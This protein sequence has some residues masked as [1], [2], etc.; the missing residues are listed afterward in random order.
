MWQKL[1]CKVP[2]NWQ[3]STVSVHAPLVVNF[4]VDVTGFVVVDDDVG[5]EPD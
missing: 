1:D 5:D 2:I 3:F 4:T